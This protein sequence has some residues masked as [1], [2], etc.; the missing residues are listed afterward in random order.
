MISHGSIY[1]TNKIY[2]LKVFSNNR[3]FCTLFVYNNDRYK[4]LCFYFQRRLECFLNLPLKVYRKNSIF[5]KSIRLVEM[6][7]IWI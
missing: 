7:T 6:K 2:S 4:T 3:F 5:S 1:F